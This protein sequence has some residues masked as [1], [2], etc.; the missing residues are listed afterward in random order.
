MTAFLIIITSLYLLLFNLFT[1]FPFYSFTF[2]L[3]YFYI[4]LRTLPSAWPR[5]FR[6]AGRLQ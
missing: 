4:T 5:A 3:F 1:F 2:L 6:H